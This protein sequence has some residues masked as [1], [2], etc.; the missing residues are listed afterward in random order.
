MSHK[1]LV[2]ILLAVASVTSVNAMTVT[3]QT[4]SEI[5]AAP[6]TK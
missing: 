1:T 5:V 2:L 6:Q 3:V 4:I